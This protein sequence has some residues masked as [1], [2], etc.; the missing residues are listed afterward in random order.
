M[1]M[2]LSDIDI[3]DYIRTHKLIIDPFDESL[4][5]ENGV[6]LRFGGSIGRFRSHN[7]LF[8]PHNDDINDV[9][10]IEKG[11][12][13]IIYPDE[14]ILFHSLEYIRLPNN[15]MGQIN[16]RSSF[17]RLGLS[18]PPTIIDANFEGQLTIGLEGGR[19]PI[20][21]R[22]GERILYIIFYELKS[23]SENPYRG[24]YRGQRGIQPPI[25]KGY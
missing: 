8:D 17:A 9:L 1:N 23:P 2:A 10:T 14:K 13:F 21:I 6:D 11:D 5:R 7:V 4:I 18:I 25:F 12:T 20:K 3:K 24:K 22:K 16:L 15:L 19:F